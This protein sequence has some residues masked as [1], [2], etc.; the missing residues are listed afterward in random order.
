MTPDGQYCINKLID[1]MNRFLDIE[2]SRFISV[3]L[4]DNFEDNRSEM[5]TIT[6]DRGEK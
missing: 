4:E 2:N 1:D 3:N 6:I 5:V